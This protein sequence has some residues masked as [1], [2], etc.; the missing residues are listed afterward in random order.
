MPFEFYQGVRLDFVIGK[1]S[2]RNQFGG[3]TNEEPALD[4]AVHQDAFRHICEAVF[5]RLSLD[6]PGHLLLPFKRRR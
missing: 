5:V 3:V 2:N 4:A 1:I 6:P